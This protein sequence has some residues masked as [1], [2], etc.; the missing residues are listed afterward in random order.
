[1]VIIF[2]SDPFILSMLVLITEPLLVSPINQYRRFLKKWRVHPQPL[3]PKDAHN[4]FIRLF[5]KAL[6]DEYKYQSEATILATNAK[7]TKL[8]KG[9]GH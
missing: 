2:Q 6:Q 5:S 9:G 3:H 7:P 1:M 8:I 4:F